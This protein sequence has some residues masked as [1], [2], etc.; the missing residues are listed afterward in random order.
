MA[1]RKEEIKFNVKKAKD[2][3]KTKPKKEETKV[4]KVDAPV[5]S[6]ED[7]EKQKELEVFANEYLGEEIFVINGQIDVDDIIEM[8][9]NMYDEI[10]I[11]SNTIEDLMACTNEEVCVETDNKKSKKDKKKKDKNKDK[12]KDKK[13]EKKD[14]KKKK[15]K[16]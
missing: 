14:K 5:Q 3:K 15:N 9:E 2:T 7:I 16:K 1:R 12:K 8:V 11:L 10:F 13:K 6:A 4:E